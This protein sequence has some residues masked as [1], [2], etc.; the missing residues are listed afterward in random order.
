MMEEELSNDGWAGRKYGQKCIKGSPY[1]RWWLIKEA[2]V[3]KSTTGEG[4]RCGR[5]KCH[6]ATCSGIS[7]WIRAADKPKGTFTKKPMLEGL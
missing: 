3:M 7:R 5:C 2:M 6:F 1:Q 4:V